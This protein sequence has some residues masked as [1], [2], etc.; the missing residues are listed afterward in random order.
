MDRMNI[1]IITIALTFYCCASTLVAQGTDTN[2]RL[3]IAQNYEETGSWEQALSIYE[4]LYKE[5]PNNIV[6]FEHLRRCYAQLKRYKDAIT[7][8]ESNLR[9]NPTNVPL[10]ANLGSLYY[11]MGIETNAD[12]IWRA[13]ILS[14]PTNINTYRMVAFELYE[15]RLY[16]KAIAL[17]TD[18]R[19]RIGNNTLFADELAS[20]YTALQEYR[21]AMQEYLIILRANPQ[22]LS[23]IESRLIQITS[24]DEGIRIAIDVVKSESNLNPADPL[25]HQVLAWLYLEA[26]EYEEAYLQNLTLEKTGRSGGAELFVF[27]QRI[28]SERVYD[29]ALKAYRYLLGQYPSAFFV[30][31]VRFDLARCVEE[32]SL[33]LDTVKA[34]TPDTEPSGYAQ[35]IS[36]Y[37]SIISDFP[38]SQ[39][40]AQAHF[41]IGMIRKDRFADLNGAITSFQKVRSHPAAG[42]LAHEATIDLGEIYIEQ[43]KLNSART[44]FLSLK[45]IPSSP[46]Y[47][48]A[49][50][51]LVQLDYYETHFD[52]ALV[53]L[54]DLTSKY[55]LDVTNDALELLYFI[56]ENLI[57]SPKGLVEFASGDLLLRRKKLSEALAQFRQVSRQYKEAPLIDDT[58]LA[59]GDI[60][61]RINMPQEAITAY[62]MVVDSIR[63]SI[64]KDRAIFKIAE[65]CQFA[66]RDFPQAISYYELLL[67]RYPSSLY[68]SEVRK[69]IRL[70]RGENI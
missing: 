38:G 27:A 48:R 5:L 45:N 32:Q 69:R 70:L 49:L 43:N 6:I 14:D 2:T 23:Y 20:L 41:R 33:S 10:Q 36:L 50:F 64:L 46:L 34:P 53:Q 9:R 59:I 54:Q 7:L 11:R 13:I 29:V 25:L 68:V 63:Q 42:T 4:S 30:A 12:S 52:T 17:Y 28:F 18:A 55:Q 47:Y 67:T 15:Q 16:D 22:Q 19:V 58:Y 40:S 60:C 57:V 39:L 35:A 51:Y 8:I 65:T 37:E 56:Q 1:V 21:K 31:N 24:R 3:R 62:R 26:K 66:L 61:V 44:E